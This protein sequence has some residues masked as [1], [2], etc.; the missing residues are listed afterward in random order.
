M[1]VGWLEQD[2]ADVAADEHWLTPGERECL[3]AMR[4]AKRR[5]DWRLGRWTAKCALAAFLALPDRAEDFAR[6]EVR[7]APSGAPEAFFLGRPAPASLSLSHSNG[8]ALCA[9]GPPGGAVGCD[10][11]RVEPRSARFVSDWFTRP[12]QQLV[13]AVPFTPRARLV[14]LL[15]SAKRYAIGRDRAIRHSEAGR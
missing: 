4:F 14:T 8:R 9:V 1:I 12:E 13:R 3:A 11:E 7:A 6:I 2:S 15:W 10:L 5:A